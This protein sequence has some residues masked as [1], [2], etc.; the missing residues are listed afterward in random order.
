MDEPFINRA[1]LQTSQPVSVKVIRKKETG[2]PAGYCF[3]EFATEEEAERVLKLVNTTEIPGSS[4]TKRFRLN[5]SQAGKNWDIGPSH[6]I[7]VGDLDNTVSD[8]KLEDFFSKQYRSVKGAKIMWEDHGFSRGYGFVRFSD[9][10]EMKR[11]LVEMQGASGLGS[12]PIRVSV[13][14]PKGKSSESSTTTMDMYTQQ[15]MQNY[16]YTQYYQYY[17]YYGYYPHQAQQYSGYYQQPNAAVVVHPYPAIA[18]DFAAAGTTQQQN[19]NHGQATCQQDAVTSGL[20][21]TEEAQ[22]SI[23]GD[24]PPLQENEANEKYFVDNLGILNDV[25]GSHWQLLNSITSKIPSLKEN[26]FCS[27]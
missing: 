19:L 12:K 21:T 14:T 4:P 1:F 16:D 18:E 6:S 7:F 15:W 8:D 13:A 27:G 22:P 26:E 20:T 17:Q 3:I 10:N 5:R 25:L 2:M 9:E 11:A 23:E 24:S